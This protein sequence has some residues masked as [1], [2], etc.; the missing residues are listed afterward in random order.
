MI[1]IKIQPYCEECRDFEPEVEKNEI[2]SFF[3][4][5]ICDTEITCR[6]KDRCEKMIEYLK[7]R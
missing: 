6:N 1:E 4:N 2:E 3:G 5:I 7:E